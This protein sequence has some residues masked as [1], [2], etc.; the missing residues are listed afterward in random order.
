LREQALRLAFGLQMPV[1][2]RLRLN[3]F[4]GIAVL[5][6][7]AGSATSALALGEKKGPLTVKTFERSNG[8]KDPLKV[9]IRRGGSDFRAGIGK[10]KFYGRVRGGEVEM[11]GHVSFDREGITVKTAQGSTLTKFPNGERK[12]EIKAAAE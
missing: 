9:T 3:V 10:M 12:I 8:R 11:R 2:M 7:L 1:A 5:L 4:V 6:T